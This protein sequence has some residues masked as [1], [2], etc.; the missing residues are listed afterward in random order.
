MFE[1]YYN[2]FKNNSK[3]N[4]LPNLSPFIIN[5]NAFFNNISS[6]AKRFKEAIENA[7]PVILSMDTLTKLGESQFVYWNYFDSEFMKLISFSDNVNK[8]LREIHEK[9][10]YKEMDKTMELCY[11][12]ILISPYKKIFS[13]SEN[14]YRQKY[15][16]LSLVGFLSIIDGLLSDVSCSAKLTSIFKRGECILKKLRKEKL[17][18]FRNEELAYVTLMFT[19]KSTMESLSTNVPFTEKEPKN[20]NRHWI[21]H[22]RSRRRKTKLDCLKLVNFIYGIILINDFSKTSMM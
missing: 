22:G 17:S 2:I 1:I 7:A 16:D 18:S 10:K 14:A 12:H 13:Q 8:T 6:F 3:N 21:M 5:V 9:S 4:E 19:F 15:Y 20:L 11:N